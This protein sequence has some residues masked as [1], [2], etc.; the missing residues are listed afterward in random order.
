MSLDQEKD[1]VDRLKCVLSKAADTIYPDWEDHWIVDD[2][3][4]RDLS[5]R[6]FC[7]QDIRVQTLTEEG[8]FLAAFQTDGNVTLLFTVGKKQKFPLCSNVSCSKQTKCICFKR[9]KK[10]LQEHEESEDEDSNY[11]WKS[12]MLSAIFCRIWLLKIIRNAMGTTDQR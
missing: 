12:Q 11:Y 2:I 9:Y 5:Y 4:G 3:D 8:R 10:L 6:V 1:V 7:N